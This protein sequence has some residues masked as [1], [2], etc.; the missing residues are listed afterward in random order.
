MSSDRRRSPRIEIL[1]R[2]HGHA[3][4]LDVPVVVREISLGGMALETSFPFP[5]GAVHEFRLT[6]GD[7]AQVQLNGRVM[8]SRDTTVPGGQAVYLTGIQF[9]DDEPTEDDSTVG[10]LI[11][12]LK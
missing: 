2:L 7:G 4:S 5:I 6:L 8:H 1:G 11:D 12:R 3:V 10:N 9:V